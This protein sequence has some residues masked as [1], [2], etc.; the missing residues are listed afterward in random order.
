MVERLTP[1]HQLVRRWQTTS[2]VTSQARD[3]P[4]RLRRRATRQELPV[5]DRL[6]VLAGRD[7]RHGEPA[8]AQRPDAEALPQGS[9]S[10]SDAAPLV[11]AAP[12]INVE[13]LTSQVIQQLDRRLIAY[14]E[15][16]GRS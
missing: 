1:I 6:N 16:M 4:A 13:A 2:L 8:P 15:R 3:V 14:R 12:P 7:R 11:P 9:R 5:P 10:R